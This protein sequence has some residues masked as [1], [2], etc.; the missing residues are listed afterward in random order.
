[1]ARA[2]RREERRRVRPEERRAEEWIGDRRTAA[3]VLAWEGSG[4]GG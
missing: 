4:A 3:P 1:M 2:R